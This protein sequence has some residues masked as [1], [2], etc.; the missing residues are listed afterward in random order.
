MKGLLLKYNKVHNDALHHLS[1]K[2]KEVEVVWGDLFSFGASMD[3]LSYST[4]IDYLESFSPLDFVVVGDV[5]WN[6]GQH[7]CRAGKKMGIRVF[8][9]QH[10]QWIYIANKKSLDYYPD[11]TLLFGEKVAEMCSSWPYGKH[12]RLSVVGSPRYDNASTNGQGAYTYFSPPVIEEIVHEKPTGRL[13]TP[14]LKSLEKISGIDKFVP[15]IIQPHYREARIDMLQKMFPKAQFAD[16]DLDALRLIRGSASILT[17]RNSTVV[18][19]A[20]AHQKPV[21]LT[22]FPETDVCFF[23]RGYFG[24]FAVE[25]KNRRNL[26]DNLL[27][28]T[29]LSRNGYSYRARPYIY[30]GDASNRVTE[31]IMQE[32]V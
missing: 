4:V 19:D 21:V 13:R 26:I 32:S 22:D 3:L 5:F 27:S 10:G 2:L 23:E 12:S 29:P 1:S 18:L 16:P 7:I 11:H 8:F 17:S 25:S 14:F 31:L 6:T 28:V 24:D 9:M 30:L 20:I 15:L